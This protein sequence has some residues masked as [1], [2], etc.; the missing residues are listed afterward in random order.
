MT[1][2]TRQ[3]IIRVGVLDTDTGFL[4]V[5]ANRLAAAGWQY[6]ALAS[7]APADAL[8]AMRLNVLIVDL[9][10]LGPPGWTYLEKVCD[11]LPA[12]AV[13]VCTGPSTVAHRVRGLRLGA[14]DWITKPCH[15][16]EVVARAEA[17]ARRRRRADT[18]RSEVGPRVVGEL[19]IHPSKFQAFAGGNSV[20]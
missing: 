8:V 10:V 7:L 18:A 20:G 6:R 14:D 9:A 11:R 19:E 2:A 12:L 13:I 15:A 3:Q 16:E 1:T 4:Q 5:L 17:V